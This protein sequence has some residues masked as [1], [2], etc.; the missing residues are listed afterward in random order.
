[1]CLGQCY[2]VLARM[3]HGYLAVSLLTL[4]S[5]RSSIVGGYCEVKQ[6]D[7]H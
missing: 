2:W 4:H 5:S 1:M 3:D 7:C 6:R